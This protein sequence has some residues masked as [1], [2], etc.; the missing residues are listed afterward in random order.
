MLL[1]EE[2][3]RTIVFNRWTANDW[4]ARATSSMMASNNAVALDGLQSYAHKEARIFRDI[5]TLFDAKWKNVRSRAAVVVSTTSPLDE[6]D[7]V[8]E[9]TAFEDEA[10]GDT[11]DQSWEVDVWDL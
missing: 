1:E 6:D 3:R 10:L 5:A 8:P 7:V 9:N 4:L 11:T 2:M